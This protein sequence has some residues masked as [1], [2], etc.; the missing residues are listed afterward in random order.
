VDSINQTPIDNS[1]EKEFDFGI[2]QND[3]APTSE[4]RSSSNLKT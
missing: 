4:R 3:L 1:P 2:E